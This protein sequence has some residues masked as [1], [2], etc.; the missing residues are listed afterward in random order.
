MKKI[1]IKLVSAIAV[2]AVLASCN[3]NTTHTTQPT[4]ENT[5]DDVTQNVTD[6]SFFEA[7]ESIMFEN[8]MIKNV[9]G[10]KDKIIISKEKYEASNSFDFKFSF[11]SK[12]AILS[13]YLDIKENDDGTIESSKMLRIDPLNKRFNLYSIEGSEQTLL[14]YAKYPF[15]T[16]TEYKVRLRN[17]TNSVSVYFGVDEIEKAP[18]IDVTC[19]RP[20]KAKLGICFNGSTKSAISEPVFERSTAPAE[21]ARYKNPMLENTII[22]D[23]TVLFYEGTYYMFTTGSFVCRTSKDLVN[24]K[25]AGS[26]ANSSGLYGTKYFGGAGIYERDGKFYML[27]TSHQTEN[28][29]LSI[30]YATSDKVL[31]PY[32]QK[33][34]ME[35]HVLQSINS[36]A[37]SFLFNDPVSGNDILYFYRTDPGVGNVLYG[38]NV[39]VEN[40]KIIMKDKNP[41]KLTEPNQAWEMKKENG[42]STPVCERPNVLY[43]DGYY[44]VFYAGS[45][46]KT[47]YS[48]G[49][50]VSDKPLSGFDKPKDTNPLLDATASLTGVGCTWIVPSPDGSEL[51]V[52]YHCHD[53]VDTFRKRRLCMDR[54]TFRE[55]PE[56]GPD[57]P[58]IHGPTV[59]YQPAP[60]K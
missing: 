28:S 14:G 52:L 41:V 31:G 10:E 7:D 34:T 32:V 27:Y 44:Y 21:D 3:G 39:S 9:D 47:S 30:F 25:E 16:K 17:L 29:G 55:N 37:G 54:L 60:S 50:I 19:K 58:V 40:G 15:Q 48:E 49:Y 57:I 5:S 56:G 23:P 45:H 20:P 36:P 4:T 12:S 35:E 51:F 22:A 43:R 38:I 46:Y 24:W 59:T 11:D 1:L 13:I 26:V 33:G 8:G 18:I 6:L 2:S 42:V 53:A